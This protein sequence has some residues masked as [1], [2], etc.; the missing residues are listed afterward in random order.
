M[1][2][3][4]DIVVPTT[5]FDLLRTLSTPDFAFEFEPDPSRPTEEAQKFYGGQSMAWEKA[6]RNFVKNTEEAFCRDR[7][8]GACYRELAKSYDLHGSLAISLF[9]HELAVSSCHILRGGL[10][11]ILQRYPRRTQERLFQTGLF[12][13]SHMRDAS[14]N[15]CD[16]REFGSRSPEESLHYIENV[17]FQAKLPSTHPLFTVPLQSLMLQAAFLLRLLLC[18]LC[19]IPVNHSKVNPVTTNVFTPRANLQILAV[20]FGI[21]SFGAERL[22]IS[23]PAALH[24][25]LVASPLYIQ[26]TET[27]APVDGADFEN[28]SRKLQGAMPIAY[29][30]I[31]L[32]WRLKFL[33]KRRLLTKG[34]GFSTEELDKI[35]CAVLR[36]IASFLWVIRPCDRGSVADRNSVYIKCSLGLQSREYDLPMLLVWC[37]QQQHHVRDEVLAALL[38]RASSLRAELISE[39]QQDMTLAQAA[40]KLGAL[41][42]L[43]P[44]LPQQ[45][46]ARLRGT[47][48]RHP[49]I[50]FDSL[51]QGEAI[52]DETAT[53]KCAIHSFWEA[54]SITRPES[55]NIS[56]LLG[57]VLGT[58]NAEECH[59]NLF[60]SY[61]K[62]RGG[63]SHSYAK[64]ELS[65]FLAASPP[66][67]KSINL[68]KPGHLNFCCTT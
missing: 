51:L 37:S 33:L 9:H 48:V 31:K 42:L 68:Q 18:F 3:P 29:P 47:P 24:Q 28:W 63:G 16:T 58:H 61:W 10:I 50:A 64:E 30:D 22:E 13:C 67:V 12:L 54:L 17:W 11:D 19:A 44:L 34:Q 14:G 25:A 21:V 26:S 38:A 62:V 7:V 55:R 35:G 60:V 27:D 20:T 5:A 52:D 8:Y 39:L 66:E 56:E 41:L 43:L 59:E 49:L 15:L 45:A 32:V 53:V 36:S 6:W 65:R 2:F 57:L 40:L 4:W 23:D 46:Q 1:G